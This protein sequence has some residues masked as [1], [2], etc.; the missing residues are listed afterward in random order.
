MF[1]LTYAIFLLAKSKTIFFI[2]GNTYSCYSCDLRILYHID[3][4]QE[5][6]RHHVC[7]AVHRVEYNRHDFH[8]VHI[9]RSRFLLIQSSQFAEKILKMDLKQIPVNFL[10]YQ[11]HYENNKTYSTFKNSFN[12]QSKVRYLNSNRKLLLDFIFMN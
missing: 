8:S 5:A 3:I 9:R 6:D 7:N 2:S 4:H 1:I 12:E 10:S 11:Q